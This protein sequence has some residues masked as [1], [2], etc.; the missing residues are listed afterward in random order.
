[1]FS[2]ACPDPGCPLDSL[3]WSTHAHARILE[4]PLRASTRTCACATT[5]QGEDVPPH[6]YLKK[7]QC[8]S[9]SYV[10]ASTFVR[11]PNQAMV[12]RIQI[13]SASHSTLKNAFAAHSTSSSSASVA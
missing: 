13:H 2:N 11:L 6:S 4:H 1:M 5:F 8:I 9:E 12:I 7:C 3:C 10:S